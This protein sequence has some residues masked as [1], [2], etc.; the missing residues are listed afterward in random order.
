MIQLYLLLGSLFVLLLLLLVQGFHLRA[1][2][3]LKKRVSETI[4]VQQRAEKIAKAKEVKSKRIKKTTKNKV[5][6][7]LFPEIKKLFRK[8]E[9]ELSRG[10]VEHAQQLLV[11]LLALDPSHKEANEKLGLIYLKT[12]QPKKA[13][14]IYENMLEVDP[15]NA[16]M[17]SNLGLAYYKQNKYK[18]AVDAYEKA[19]EIDSRKPGRYAALGQ[20]YLLVHKPEKALDNFEKACRRDRRNVEYLFLVSEAQ[21]QMG[22]WEDCKTTLEK[23]LGIQPYNQAAKDE[24]R[25]LSE[26]H[27]LGEPEQV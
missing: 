5:D 21:K 24:L 13:E 15:R 20:I 12:D 17:L 7:K 8:A 22:K 25:K 26:R 16:V 19:I 6:S 10:D 4:K 2:D 18:E 27:V 23:I 14:L 9:T 11:Q 1:L 3:R